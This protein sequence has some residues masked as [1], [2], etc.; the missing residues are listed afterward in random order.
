MSE[1]EK[2]KKKSKKSKKTGELDVEKSKMLDMVASVNGEETSKDNGEKKKKRKKDKQE[3]VEKEE[4]SPVAKKLKVMEEE[5]EK[6]D[7]SKDK[8]KKKEKKSKK[9]KSSPSSSTGGGNEKLQSQNGYVQHAAV[10]AMTADEV[11]AFRTERAIGV[12]PPAASE[13]YKPLLSFEHL[14]PTLGQSCPRVTEYIRV[15]EFVTP[16]PIQAQCWPP[17]LAGKD[18]VG[19][20][21]LVKEERRRNVSIPSL[22]PAQHLSSATKP[23]TTHP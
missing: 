11:E 20:Y 9:D 10:G 5:A 7:T 22:C 3:G 19:K 6:E 8:K 4:S 23:I 18:V 15:K 14:L 13:F 16:S 1:I 12:Y 21:N 17:L 2:K